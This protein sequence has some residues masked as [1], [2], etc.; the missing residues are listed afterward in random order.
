MLLPMEGAPRLSV[1]RVPSFYFTLYLLLVH[2]GLI[3]SLAFYSFAPF[4]LAP[5]IKVVMGL[6]ILGHGLHSHQRYNHAGHTHWIRRLQSGPE[7]VTLWQQQQT[8]P[9]VLEQATVWPWLL[10]LNLRHRHSGKRQTLY[11]FPD[12][13]APEQQR[14]LRVWLRHCLSAGH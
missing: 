13:A 7:G 6:V 9:V 14:Q 2:A 5:F 3:A 4:I 10:V 8:I 11:F 1:E 12:S